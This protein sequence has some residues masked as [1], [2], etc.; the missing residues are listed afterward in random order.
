MNYFW[1]ITL[2]KVNTNHLPPYWLAQFK[3]PVLNQSCFVSK[4]ELDF[5][6]QQYLFILR[7]LLMYFWTIFLHFSPPPPL[8]APCLKK[9]HA[10]QSNFQNNC[11]D[12]SPLPHSE[13]SFNLFFGWEIS[14][15]NLPLFQ[16]SKNCVCCRSEIICSLY[17][18]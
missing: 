6:I 5:V 17:Y 2:P 10:M 12:Q 7:L 16:L 4:K 3:A 18:N 8:P 15:K 14:K 13:P 11:R 9:K 1:L